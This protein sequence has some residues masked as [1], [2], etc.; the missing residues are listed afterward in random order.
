MA[1]DSAANVEQAVDPASVEWE[2]ISTSLGDEWDFERDGALIAH[3]V[4]L[5]EKE[6]N[7]IESG[8][9]TA[10]QFA[11]INDPDRVVFVWASADLQMFTGG[12]S[13]DLIRVGDLV[14]IQFLG[15]DQFTGAD[16][17]PRQ[18]KRYRVQAAKRG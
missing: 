2:T 12:D 14:K 8:K 6:T 13:A 10:V 4:G 3:F 7:K 1:K 15:R 5:V 18:I 17:S 11:P 16:G 9:A